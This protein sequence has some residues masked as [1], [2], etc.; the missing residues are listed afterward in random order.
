MDRLSYAERLRR[1]FRREVLAPLDSRVAGPLRRLRN[2]GRSFRPLFVT[3]AMGSGT[4]LLALSLGQRFDF[5]CII[6]ESAHQVASSSCLYNPGVDAFPS[7]R[8][9]EEAIRPRPEWRPDSI[10]EDLLALYRTFAT[11]SSDRALDKG[12]NTS[13]VRSDLLA[14]VFPTG[15][16][17]VVFRDPVV[18]IE[19]FRRKWRTFGTDALEESIR[20][21]GAIHESFLEASAGF[22]DRVSWLAYESLVEDYDGVLDELGR[23]LELRPATRAQRLP[24]RSNVPG[25]GVRNVTR[26]GIDLVGDANR[27]AYTSLEGAVIERI[28]E[29]LG[30]L[31]ERMRSLALPGNDARQDPGVGVDLSG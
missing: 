3:G 10:R 23:R 17:L 15:Q 20:F 19:G 16:F 22:A 28:R 5:A 30:P 11:G 27:R 14:R 24:R 9:Y 25:Q 13:L 29:R 4:T 31:H 26:N 18:N 21:Y 12:P 7:V 2:S 8:A 1:R 6:T